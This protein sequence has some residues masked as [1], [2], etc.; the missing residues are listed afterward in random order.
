MSL[1]PDDQKEITTLLTKTESLCKCS[2][3]LS[4]KELGCFSK[5]HQSFSRPYHSM[6]KAN[7]KSHSQSNLNFGPPRKNQAEYDE[8]ESILQPLE[9]LQMFG[10]MIRIRI[11]N[12][13]NDFNMSIIQNKSPSEK[14]RKELKDLLKNFI[15]Q[16]YYGIFKSK[17]RAKMRNE[18]DKLPKTLKEYVNDFMI[19]RDTNQISNPFHAGFIKFSRKN[20]KML[21]YSSNKRVIKKNI[22][23]DE[24]DGRYEFDSDIY[25]FDLNKEENL[26][27]IVGGTGLLKI[28]E[29]ESG[30][31]IKDISYEKNFTKAIISICV[32]Y[33]VLVF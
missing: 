29:V 23:T 13:L 11:V 28:F 21:F 7:L 16:E 26:I 24:I 4:K 18:F 15:S 30:L 3:K 5:P 8:F 12:F 33:S 27:F 32:N 2:Q 9:N 20:S 1:K 14:N 6:S 25:S 31:E 17:I 22:E 10:W 19:K